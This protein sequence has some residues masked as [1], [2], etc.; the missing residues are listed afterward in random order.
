LLCLWGYAY[1]AYG[2]S[3]LLKP[4]SKELGFTRAQTSIAASIA[5]FEG[6]LDAAIVGYLSDRYG[7]RFLVF[8]GVF[9]TGLGLVLMNYI[10]SLWS[11]YLVWS[12]ISSIGI[13]ISL[14]M[15][16]DV[17]ITNWFI[18]KR[19]TAMSIRWLFSGLSG[20]I[21]LP[22]VA[23]LIVVV[24]WRMACVIGGLGMWVVGLPLV[25]F[26]IKA[27][28][29]E[30]YGLLPDGATQM[31][32]GADGELLTE[33]EYA[34]QLGE[35][36]FTTVQ[37]LKT[38]A[39]WLMIFAYMFHAALYPV[40]NIHC[41]P[42]LTDRGMEP[43][44]AAATMSIFVTASIPARFLGGVIVDRVQTSTIRF[45]MAGA[46]FMQAAGVTIFLLDQQSML[47]LY[48]FFIVYGIGMGATMPMS[49]VLQSR[50]FGRPSFGTIAGI[51]RVL[52]MPV[53]ILGPVLAGWIYDRTGSYILAFTLF[54]VTLAL[55]GVIMCFVR[56]PKPPTPKNEA[57]QN[58]P[59]VENAA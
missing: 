42:F 12:V 14:G 5:R 32:T 41:I 48:T 49:P 26:F 37:A 25:F 28:R 20:V 45:L 22:I 23:W 2:F 27:R 21:G 54:A 46:F 55:A 29:P 7:P 40:M 6:G 51:S 18:K 13:N 30:Y 9:L 56:R 16:L 4:L 36:E 8:T 17:A 39:F 11:F 3:A 53:G 52:N 58:A 57:P 15:P 1:L 59:P 35:V 38:S 10:N 34:A 19:G 50:Y 31:P 43:L 47:A 44:R 33:A 24:G